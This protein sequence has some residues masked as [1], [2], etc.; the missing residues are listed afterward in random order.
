MPQANGN[1]AANTP[2]HYHDQ[3]TL[4]G[5]ISIQYQQNEQEQ[6]VS[7]SFDWQQEKDTISITLTSPLR[8]TIAVIKQTPQGAT[9]E[10]AKQETRTAPDIE[11][12]LLETMGWSLP[13]SGLKNWL[14][15]FDQINGAMGAERHSIPAI[16]N[17]MLDA[18][19]WQLRFVSWQVEEGNGSTIHPKRIDL[20]RHTKHLGEIRIR[21]VISEWK[22]P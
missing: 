22:T 21:I 16:D 10:Q 19:G 11:Q 7:G 17:H 2:R 8:Q 1:S 9:L 13:V 12:L 20:V 18:Q 5:P 6:S 15:G 14:Q 4:N 3:I